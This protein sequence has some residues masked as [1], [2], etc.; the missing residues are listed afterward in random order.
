MTMLTHDLAH[1]SG[2]TDRPTRLS[3]ARKAQLKRIAL[4][5]LTALSMA[6]VLTALI[7]LRTAIYVW[8]LH[9]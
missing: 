9:A 1:Q 6:S 5:A 4:G 3:R 7:A 2:W 8:H